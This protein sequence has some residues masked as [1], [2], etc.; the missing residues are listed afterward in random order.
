[1]RCDAAAAVKGATKVDASS[2]RFKKQPELHDSKMESSRI[3]MEALEDVRG[4]L[5]AIREQTQAISLQR[6]SGSLQRTQ[7]LI[8]VYRRT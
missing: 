4:P 1:V 2:H 6:N 7:Q 3:G 5:A 8:E